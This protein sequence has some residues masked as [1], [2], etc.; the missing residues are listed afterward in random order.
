MESVRQS[1]LTNVLLLLER[2]TSEPET[3]ARCALALVDEAVA[4]A[5]NDHEL[6]AL[7]KRCLGLSMRS[8]GHTQDALAWLRESVDSALAGGLL[9]IAASSNLAL[10]STLARAGKFPAALE[11]VEAALP[12]LSANEVA[13]ALSRRA[14]FLQRLERTSQAVIAY[15][16]A[17]LRAVSDNKMEEL[18]KTLNNRGLFRV[19]LGDMEGAVSDLL[20]SSKQFLNLGLVDTSAAI[21]HNLGWCFAR[22]GLVVEALNAYDR[23][24]AKG[25]L[26]TSATWEGAFDRAE[27]Y[28]SARLLSEALYSATHADRLAEEAGF[29]SEVPVISLQLGRIQAALGDSGSA[30]KQFAIAESRFRDQGAS[31]SA[32]LAGLCRL[33]IAD[34]TRTDEPPPVP[35]S[36]FD[37]LDPHGY[38]DTLVDVAYGELLRLRLQSQPGEQTKR[39]WLENLLENGLASTSSLSRLQACAARLVMLGLHNNLED[40]FRVQL[41]EA[42]EKLFEELEHHLEGIHSQELRTVVVDK[43]ELEALFCDAALSIGDPAMFELWIGRLRAAVSSLPRFNQPSGQADNQHDSLRSN[44]IELVDLKNLRESST[45][46]QRNAL[47]F[48]VRSTHWTTRARS[49][50]ETV[51]SDLSR[52]AVVANKGQVILVYA[53]DSTNVV[54]SIV[55]EHSASIEIV[56]SLREIR[57][58]SESV[59]LG[60]A[61]LFGTNIRG[62]ERGEQRAVSVVRAIDRL[63]T[64]VLPVTLPEGDL[65]IS[66]TG[67][68]GGVP[69]SLF[70]RLAGRSITL[71]SS[72]FRAAATDNTRQAGP[73]Q[74]RV[75]IVEGPELDYASGEVDA[76][77][78][79]YANPIVLRG[80]DATVEAVCDLLTSADVVHVAAHGRRRVDNALFS[81]IDLFDGPLMAYDIERLSQTPKTVILSCCDLGASNSQGA[82][83]LLGFSGALVSRGTLQ[84]AAAVLPVS[85][86]MSRSVM[87]RLHEAMHR[88]LS[89][90]QAVAH[91]V[92]NAGS[93]FERVTA[94]SY[95]VKGP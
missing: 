92:A 55:T 70:P 56:G 81:G 36:L 35:V 77:L 74:A 38:R 20:E 53:Q 75:G 80:S 83:G 26:G 5:S 19:D 60:A 54:V 7:M 34:Q 59:C 86:E 72:L 84:V 91:G 43:L 65:L 52:S 42:A 25:G 11:A 73:N 82:F 15:Q 89:V 69:W 39:L 30:E 50:V 27:V 71:T 40:D 41:V 18:A 57:T 9:S 63:E 23:S 64:L 61:A 68:L 32:E 17:I 24:D 51:Q 10:G 79:L 44:P 94:G 29:E 37:D 49:P 76:L 87:V 88:G 90:S 28:I 66:T 21:D 62:S 93:L 22:Q 85:D 1:A 46:P 6:L 16:G 58:R 31:A 95:V 2:V 8:L 14:I 33:I 67:C 48:A 12:F 47:E 4:A 78:R 13:A 45:G 3:A